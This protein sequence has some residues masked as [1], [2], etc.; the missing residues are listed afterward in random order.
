MKPC[1]YVGFTMDDPIPAVHTMEE[2]KLSGNHLKG[3]RPALSFDKVQQTLP[4]FTACMQYSPPSSAPPPQSFDA[5]PHWQLLKEV[6]TQVF[7]TPQD[8]PKSKPFFDHVL[9]FS[10]ADGR[11]W[12]RNYQVLLPLDG[13]KSIQEGLSTVEVGPRCCLNPIVALE[14]GFGGR[15]LYENPT[16]VSP[17]ALR[18]A[19]K[20]KH[21]SKY[22]TKVTGKEK[23]KKHKA[24]NV[25]PKNPLADVFRG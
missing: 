12:I 11:V 22:A 24:A 21:G 14:G 8:H 5:E 25:V 2:L 16:Y 17:N 10:I 1:L 20:S 3:S 23:R 7:A 18:A 6:L 4:F 9:T 19:M 13:K 15:V